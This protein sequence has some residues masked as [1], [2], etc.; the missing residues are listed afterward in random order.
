MGYGSYSVETLSTPLFQRTACQRAYRTSDTTRC[1]VLPLF[2]T[3]CKPQVSKSHTANETLAPGETI[4][5]S[6]LQEEKKMRVWFGLLGLS[7]LVATSIA[8]GGAPKLEVGAPC[9]KS[10][11]CNSENKLTCLSN[12]VGGYCGVEG[13]TSNSGCPA[14]SICISHNNGKKYCFKACKEKDEC[15]SNASCTGNV[16]FVDGAQGDKACVPTNSN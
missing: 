15:S 9:T 11:E 8:C 14:G 5:G 6:Q 7:L 13:C 2:H 10:A 16:I 1:G 4:N 12:F 3:Q